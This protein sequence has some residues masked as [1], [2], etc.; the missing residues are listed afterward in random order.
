MRTKDACCADL[1]LHAVEDE[2]HAESLG[3]RPNGEKIESSPASW[4]AGWLAGERRV[5]CGGYTGIEKTDCV[6]EIS[7]S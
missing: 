5:V 4:L 2:V 3:S 6:S 7:S 1:D